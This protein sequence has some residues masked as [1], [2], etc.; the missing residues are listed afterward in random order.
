MDRLGYVH[1]FGWMFLSLARRRIREQR[2]A[3]EKPHTSQKAKSE[4]TRLSR[5][6]DCFSNKRNKW[7]TNGYKSYNHCIYSYP[8]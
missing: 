5:E 6:E 3:Q 1:L 4:P 2:V 7:E 8:Y